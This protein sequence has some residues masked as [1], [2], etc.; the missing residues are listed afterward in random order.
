MPLISLMV[1]ILLSLF[2]FAM[3]Q[4]H[5]FE[6]AFAKLGL[7]PQ[8]ALTVLLGTLLG[9]GINIPLFRLKIKEAGHLVTMPGRKPVW[10]LYQPAKEGYTVIA[11]NVGGGLIPIGLSLYF[12]S[13][14]VVAGADWL[15][16]LA[17]V[18]AISYKL[19]RPIPGFGIGMP[20]LIAPLASVFIALMLD[21][22]HA[23]QLAYISGVLGVLIGADILRIKNIASLGVP[24]ASIGGAG[25]FDGIF[26][27]GIIAALLA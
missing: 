18:T 4:I 17:I 9:S 20:I 13:L 26:M 6:I 12:I 1:L 2:L 21:R 5:V 10:E 14:Q 7:A 16:A 15:I 27:T 23:A 8:T 24:L 11:V 22:A 19:S 25:T 3:I